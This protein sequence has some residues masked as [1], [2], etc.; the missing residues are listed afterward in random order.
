M[1]QRWNAKEPGIWLLDS[2][3]L[4]SQLPSAACN[5]PAMDPYLS[6]VVHSSTSALVDAGVHATSSLIHGYQQR[7]Q[8]DAQNV[9]NLQ[10]E[11]HSREQPSHIADDYDTQEVAYVKKEGGDWFA[12]QCKDARLTVEPIT[13]VKM[14]WKKRVSPGRSMSVS[15]VRLQTGTRPKLTTRKPHGVQG[16]WVNIPL[17]KGG[18]SS[19]RGLSPSWRQVARLL[20][21]P[22]TLDPALLHHN[23]NSEADPLAVPLP[24]VAL[25]ALLATGAKLHVDSALEVRVTTTDQYSTMRIEDFEDASICTKFSRDLDRGVVF[26]VRSNWNFAAML[27]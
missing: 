8:E 9:N 7:L 5:I 26:V 6:L 1:K 23:N 24:V 17:V 16:D 13:H 18:A 19:S 3:T 14:A 10:I 2:T 15:W 22:L 11:E 20:G 21:I 12:I 4:P 25:F 27:D